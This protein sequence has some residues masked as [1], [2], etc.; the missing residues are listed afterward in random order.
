[1]SSFCVFSYLVAS[2]NPCCGS[3]VLSAYYDTNRGRCPLLANS[4]FVSPTGL[5]R[6]S[7]TAIMRLMMFIARSVRS[8]ERS[9]C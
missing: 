5:T 6:S 1:M 3:W 8:S 9:G 7:P 4:F 2:T